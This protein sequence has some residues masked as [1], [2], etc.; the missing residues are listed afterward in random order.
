MAL[1]Q[2]KQQNI[3]VNKS[4]HLIFFED[5]QV[6]YNYKTQQWTQIPAYAGLGFFSINSK[7]FDV[8]LVIFSAGSVDL[9][10]Q[11]N[12]YVP[13]TAIITTGAPNINPGG[14]AVVGGVRPIVNGGTYSVR[15]G[16]QDKPD[17]AVSYSTATSINARSGMANFRSEGRYV[18]AELTI[19]G[20]FDT[21]MG[22][23]IDFAEQG[24]T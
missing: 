1:G 16:V 22:A 12:T 21:A 10:A 8:G 7:A 17:D 11:A 18:R 14:R 2:V 20:G 23:D 6:C 4:R 5:D 24:R 9:Q 3:A 13:Q 15:V 19:T